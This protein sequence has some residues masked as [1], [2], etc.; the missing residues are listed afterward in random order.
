MYISEIFK[1]TDQS[2]IAPFIKEKRIGTLIRS[3]ET[4]PLG[5]H[6]SMELETNSKV[7]KILGGPISKE[8]RQWIDFDKSPFSLENTTKS[9]QKTNE[10]NCWI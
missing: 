3:G 1:I 10:Q 9:V 2:I 6:I 8:N 4:Y 5:T 7:E